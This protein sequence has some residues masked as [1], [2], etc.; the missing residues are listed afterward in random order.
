MNYQMLV[1]DIDGTLTNSKKEISPK[2]LEALLRLQ[3]RGIKLVLAS[4]RPTA[5][6]LSYAETLQLKEFNNYIL[7]FNGARITNCTTG[8]IVYDRTLPPEV[9][10]HLFEVAKEYEVGLVTYDPDNNAV[11]GVTPDP[12]MEHEARI[13]GLPLIQVDNFTEYVSF[14]VNK[15]LMTGKPEL[16]EKL[17]PIIQSRFHGLINAYRS[18]PY[19]LEITPRHIDKANSLLKLLTS[20]GLTTDEMIC[21]GDGFNDISMIVCAG[22]GVAMANAQL[23]VKQSADIVTLSNDEDGL[24]PIIETY[25]PEK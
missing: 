17:V 3:K 7:S 10:P 23:P 16:L 19:F 1:L 6:M 5:G 8:E 22:L 9:I 24:L 20:L 14:P 11:T 13:N 12:Y 15:C 4:G 2:T 21:C 25:F 18:E